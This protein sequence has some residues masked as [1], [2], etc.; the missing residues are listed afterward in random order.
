MPYPKPPAGTHDIGQVKYGEPVIRPTGL[1]GDISFPDDY[2][3]EATRCTV[4]FKTVQ[5]EISDIARGVEPD[6]IS[7][8][9]RI[10]SEVQSKYPSVKIYHVRAYYLGATKYE[11]K[12]RHREGVDKIV[13]EHKFKVEVDFH[14]SP[15]PAAIIAAIP[16]IITAIIAGAIVATIIILAIEISKIFKIAE[17]KKLIEQEKQKKEIEVGQKILETE[18]Y[19][20]F[21]RYLEGL[22][23]LREKEKTGEELSPQ[24]ELLQKIL[25]WTAIL[26]VIGAILYIVVL[27][28]ERYVKKK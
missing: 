16:T 15:I 21:I 6:W 26:G 19:E 27:F 14:D 17:E 20:A 11:I 8:A 4:T 12:A 13:Y 23:V 1:K 22:G 5:V 10:R 2:V 18:G 9:N 3:G 25:L 28:V 7:L 24:E